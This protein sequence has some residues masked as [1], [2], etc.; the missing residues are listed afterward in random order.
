MH[1]ETDY[2]LLIELALHA[3]IWYPSPIEEN[4]RFKCLWS[5]NFVKVLHRG[6]WEVDAHTLGLTMLL[7]EL[8]LYS[9]GIH[10]HW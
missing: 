4:C 2:M 9:L 8:A 7:F 3:F 10:L 1:T 6:G 5:A